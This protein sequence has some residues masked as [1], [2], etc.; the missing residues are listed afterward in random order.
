[1]TGSIILP[2]GTYT[3]TENVPFISDDE[4]ISMVSVVIDENS[5]GATI[6]NRVL[7]FNDDSDTLYLNITNQYRNTA[8]IETT[9]IGKFRLYATSSI[10]FGNGIKIENFVN[11][12]AGVTI[13]QQHNNVT[14]DAHFESRNFWTAGGQTINGSIT[15][16]D[17]FKAEDQGIFGNHTILNPDT[18]PSYIIPTFTVTSGTT[19]APAILPPDANS[20][21][22]Y[23]IAIPPG[24][25]DRLDYS[26]SSDSYVVRFM[27]G[28]IHCNMMAFGNSI[29]LTLSNSTPQNPTRIFCK[30]SFSIGNTPLFDGRGGDAGTYNSL[31][32]YVDQ[33]NFDSGTQ[34]EINCYIIV[35]NG[36]VALAN[37]NL[38]IG[39][40]WANNITMS[41]GTNGGIGTL[42]LSTS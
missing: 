15:Y 28:D 4:E 33:G 31:V 20:N 18:I 11:I 21:G 40:V 39:V 37:N 9:D 25:Y 38:F 7:T 13:T 23:I 41:A 2:V 19:P 34:G 30:N 32:I 42:S 24:N 8:P 6:N 10:T 22:K 36:D 17:S 3:V 35:P 27:P 16:V 29:P 1:M 14:Q 5:T 26:N 12:G